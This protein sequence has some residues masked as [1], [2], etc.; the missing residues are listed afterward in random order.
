MKT[1]PILFNIFGEISISGNQMRSPS[2][3]KIRIFD[4]EGLRDFESKN[5]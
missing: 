2:R 1:N 3:P 4:L 5:F